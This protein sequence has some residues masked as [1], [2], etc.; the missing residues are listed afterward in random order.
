MS[1][2]HFLTASQRCST[3]VHRDAGS[4]F[5]ITLRQVISG[6]LNVLSGSM[7][8]YTR[9]NQPPRLDQTQSQ[10]QRPGSMDHHFP[11]ALSHLISICWKRSRRKLLLTTR[12]DQPHRLDQPQSQRQRLR[13]L[14]HRN[15]LFDQPQDQRD[16][17][18]GVNPSSRTTRNGPSRPSRREI[19]AINLHKSIHGVN[20]GGR[21]P[22]IRKRH[23]GQNGV[24]VFT[25][26]ACRLLYLRIAWLQTGSCG[27]PRIRQRR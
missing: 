27:M 24:E 4:Y 23:L 5:L 3:K 19:D 1:G 7:L 20:R 2:G 18:T 21:S 14:E 10:R 16:G 9:L 22:S 26:S 8:K 11:L 12:L 6:W 15:T 17:A 25:T 13:N